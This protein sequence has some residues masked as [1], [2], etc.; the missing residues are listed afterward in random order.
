[1][2]KIPLPSSEVKKSHWLEPLKPNL[3]ITTMTYVSRSGSLSMLKDGDSICVK[4]VSVHKESVEVV[5]LLCCCLRYL[6]LRECLPYPS[7]P[8]LVSARGF[9]FCLCHVYSTVRSTHPTTP[10]KDFFSLSRSRD[11]RWR[12]NSRSLRHI[13]W[14]WVV[15]LSQ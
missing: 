4:M 14:P 7:V 13:V 15:S 8:V 11:L 5:A 9:F 1:M 3:R 12:L 2:S 6:K 10:H